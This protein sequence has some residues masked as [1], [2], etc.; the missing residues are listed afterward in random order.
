MQ[1]NVPK[2]LNCQNNN[3]FAVFIG[4]IPWNLLKDIFRREKKKKIKKRH[5]II[6]SGICLDGKMLRKKK[7]Q[8][9]IEFCSY[10]TCYNFSS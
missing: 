1:K 10:R 6:H 5:A 4:E 3:N 2:F 8:I 7:K 9:E